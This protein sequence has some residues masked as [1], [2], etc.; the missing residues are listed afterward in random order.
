MGHRAG[1]HR[2]GR[3]DWPSSA[4]GQLLQRPEVRV[5]PRPRGPIPWERR[6]PPVCETLSIG[7][8]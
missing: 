4:D 8:L 1:C 5:G 2:T 7:R 6:W 3:K